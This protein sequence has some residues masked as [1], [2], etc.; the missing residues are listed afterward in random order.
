MVII[1]NTYRITLSLLKERLRKWRESS[2][3]QGL[4]L[5]F[6]DYDI[7]VVYNPQARDIV[8]K[9]TGAAVEVKIKE[10]ES[11]LGRGKVLYFLCPITQRKCRTLYTDGRVFVSRYAFPHRYEKQTIN[12]SYRYTKGMADP[13]RERGKTTYRGKITPYG[14][15]MLRYE[16]HLHRV[17]AEIQALEEGL[18][19][20]AKSE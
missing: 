4:R 5:S 10:E 19:K 15:R 9:G 20:S 2:T 11:N 6:P 16:K 13:Y 12:S 1:E 14:K 17:F 8:F 7:T 18:G 3:P